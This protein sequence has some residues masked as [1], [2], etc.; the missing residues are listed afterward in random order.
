MRQIGLEPIRRHD[1]QL[2]FAARVSDANKK[3]PLLSR[4]IHPR[5]PIAQRRN[6]TAF[7]DCH[8]FAQTRFDD[9]PVF[10]IDRCPQ[11]QINKREND[12]PRSPGKP[13]RAMRSV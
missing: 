6:A 13:P 1:E 9:V 5:S 12:A 7:I 3:H 2:Y 11:E 8:V 10:P 4:F